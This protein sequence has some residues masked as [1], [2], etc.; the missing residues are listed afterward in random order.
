QVAVGVPV[1][2]E[3]IAVAAYLH[4]CCAG[5]QPRGLWRELAAAF[6]LEEPKGAAEVARHDVEQAVAIEVTRKSPRAN[7]VGDVLLVTGQDQWFAVAAVKRLG[8][9]EVAVLLAVEH[10]EQAS[11]VAVM[12]RV[13]TRQ[14]I[15]N[16]ITI[17]VHSVWR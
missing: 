6:A 4:V 9:L 1:H 8:L 16:A 14:D 3:R 13:R 12:P 11:H 5:L 15:E 7:H 10:L 17:D 2:Q